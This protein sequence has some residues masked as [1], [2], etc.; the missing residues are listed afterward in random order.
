MW[1]A[2]HSSGDQGSAADRVCDVAQV[3]GPGGVVIGMLRHALEYGPAVV[4]QDSTA[5]CTI[6]SSGKRWAA[7]LSA[8][9]TAAAE[10]DEHA[11]P[12]G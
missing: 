6:G 8:G 12:A 11:E 4:R 10:G 5:E 3:R 1:A 2:V 9:F 7:V